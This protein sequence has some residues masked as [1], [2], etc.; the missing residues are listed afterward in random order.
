MGGRHLHTGSGQGSRKEDPV[1]GPKTEAT[2]LRLSDPLY[3]VLGHP[4][5]LLHLSPVTDFHLLRLGSAAA[6]L[7]ALWKFVGRFFPSDPND[8][9]LPFF[10]AARGGGLAWLAL[11]VSGRR[12]EELPLITPYQPWQ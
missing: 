5:R 1:A 6:L 4:R 7:P 2:H 9:H 12:T 8:R 3:L 11:L 10:L